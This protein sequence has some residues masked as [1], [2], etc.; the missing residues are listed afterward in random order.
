IGVT[1]DPRPRQQ[2]M[3][4]QSFDLLAFRDLW[5]DNRSFARLKADIVHTTNR[6]RVLIL[7]AHRVAEHLHL[8]MKGF[9]G[10]PRGGNTL[11][12]ESI[13]RMQKSDSEAAGRS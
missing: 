5:L 9:L 12:S 8:D 2:T 4:E 13:Q 1:L 10:E 3:I 7:T 6:R 11:P